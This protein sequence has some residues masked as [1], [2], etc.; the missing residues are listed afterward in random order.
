[1]TDLAERITEERKKDKPDITLIKNMEYDLVE[2]GT[3]Q[4]PHI[5]NAMMGVSVDES[6]RLGE[7]GLRNEHFYNIGADAMVSGTVDNMIEQVKRER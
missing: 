6:V 3:I 1:M 4:G 7:F 2:E 5:S